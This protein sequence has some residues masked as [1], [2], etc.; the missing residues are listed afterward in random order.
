V[1]NEGRVSA[2]PALLVSIAIAALIAAGLSLPAPGRAGGVEL[3]PVIGGT[4]MRCYDFRGIP[5]RTVRETQLGD[6]GR[7]RIIIR[8]PVI[9]LD[10]DR[11]A[12]L[13]PKL[14]LFFYGHECAHHVL[15]HL[16][17]PTGSSE[18]EADCWAVQFERDK[19]LLTRAD[20]ESFAP[21]LAASRGSP[22]G[23]L[24]GPAR[25]ALL[26]KCFDDRTSAQASA[27]D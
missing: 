14:Q 2:K 15:G 13:P 1:A 27:H 23:H 11:M 5:V 16:F 7:A 3:A 17:N 21:F 6:V 9:A 8:M 10:D 24:P 22:F 26:L 20:V 25:Q 19:G 18:Q 12:T 4:P